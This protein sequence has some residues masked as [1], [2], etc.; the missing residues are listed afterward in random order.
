MK[1]T[2]LCEN[3]NHRF[4]IS[5]PLN[6]YD[7]KIDGKTHTCPN[8]NSLSAKRDFETDLKSITYQE[9]PKTLGSLCDKNSDKMS[10]DEKHHLYK[11][12]NSYKD[13]PERMKLPEG[14]E[15]MRE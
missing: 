11:K 5:C 10:S 2:F 15:Y 3:C 9:N 13:N 7:D 1:Y 8:C 14:M 6:E 4:E 12:H